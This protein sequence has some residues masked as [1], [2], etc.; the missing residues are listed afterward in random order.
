LEERDLITCHGKAYIE[1]Q[2]RV[3]MIVPLP[4]KKT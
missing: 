2:Q 3:S 1:Y 4:P